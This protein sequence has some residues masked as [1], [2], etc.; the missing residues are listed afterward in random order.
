MSSD[1]LTKKLPGDEDLRQLIYNLVEQVKTLNDKVDV[2][3]HDTRPLWEGVIARLDPME[4]ELKR[5]DSI[6]RELKRLDV[7]ESELK[8]LRA[9]TQKGFRRM[10]RVMSEL[11]LNYV[12]T[13]TNLRYLEE[14]VEKLE[15]KAS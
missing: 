8:E 9:D 12:E 13:N 7:I 11:S 6:E 1:D 5:L 15:E 10:E 3:L 4:I 14:R 2:R